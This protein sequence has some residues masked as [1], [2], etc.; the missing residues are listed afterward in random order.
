MTMNQSKLKTSGKEDG[1][2]RYPKGTFPDYD[3]AYQ[4]GG[5]GSSVLN[6]SKRSG[7]IKN[8]G[9]MSGESG[10]QGTIY[11]LEGIPGYDFYKRGGAQF[12]A[13]IP[14]AKE[15][16]RDAH[17]DFKIWGKEEVKKGNALAPPEIWPS[18]LLA[19]RLKL[20]AKLDIRRRELDK[21]EG[22]LTKLED[23]QESDHAQNMLRYGPMLRNEGGGG[24][25]YDPP[26]QAMDGQ[27]VSRKN[28]LPYINEEASPYHLM[29]VFFYKKMAQKWI[30]ENGLNR[31]DLVKRARRWEQEQEEKTGD[32]VRITASKFENMMKR[33]DGYT[34]D[35][36]L[37]GI[38]NWP[39]SKDW[40]QWPKEAQ[41]IDEIEFEENEA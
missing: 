13:L 37:P 30:D 15:N 19:Q 39:Q 10:L 22:K 20:E 18:N 4:N 2:R 28:G 17:K 9:S 35:N 3:K 29:P 8:F 36:I 5:K 16:L 11:E 12:K 24:S 1:S 38:P 27:T 41:K 40:P 6:D 23:P 7:D 26:L 34:D 33:K 21:A 25:T 31:N 32:R 14:S